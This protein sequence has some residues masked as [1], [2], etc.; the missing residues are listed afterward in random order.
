MIAIH[1]SL[2]DDAP[3]VVEFLRKYDFT[4]AAQVAAEAY[5]SE[6]GA[7]FDEVAVW[8]LK[9]QEDFWVP[10]VTDEAAEKIKEALA[11]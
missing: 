5:M 10:F 11:G 2:A 6:T 4:A 1:S 7:E 3:D 9:N 8:W